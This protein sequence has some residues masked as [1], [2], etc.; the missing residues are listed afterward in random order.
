MIC[1]H[2]GILEQIQPG[3]PTTWATCGIFVGANDNLKFPLVTRWLIFV[4]VESIFLTSCLGM[5][6]DNLSLNSKN[7]STYREDLV[8]GITKSLLYIIVE[9]CIKLVH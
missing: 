9:K 4:H 1:T 7:S 3:C 2:N 6:P 5:G 8:P